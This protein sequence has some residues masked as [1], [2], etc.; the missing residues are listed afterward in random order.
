M[1][2]FSRRGLMLS[3]VLD[4]LPHIFGAVDVEVSSHFSAYFSAFLLDD[5]LVGVC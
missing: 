2:V 3:G 1:K 4:C 5:C